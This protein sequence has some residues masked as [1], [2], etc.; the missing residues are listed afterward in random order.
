M[1]WKHK[2]RLIVIAV[3]FIGVVMSLFIFSTK[4]Y[5]KL[6]SLTVDKGQD[7]SDYL[8][9][10][11]W[12]VEFKKP[13]DMYDLVYTLINTSIGEN[14]RVVENV[15]FSTH[16]LINLDQSCGPQMGPIGVL[17]GILGRE[18]DPTYFQ[19]RNIPINFMYSTYLGDRYYF[20]VRPQATCSDNKQVQEIESE[21]LLK[22]GAAITESLRI[23]QTAQ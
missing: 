3:I 13:S 1:K 21:Q 18:N 16:K 11:E 10:K 17:V 20:F 22:L 5:T 23:I 19:D 7:N 2:R 9:I 4:K 15:Y 8:Q 14:D 12:G 6:N